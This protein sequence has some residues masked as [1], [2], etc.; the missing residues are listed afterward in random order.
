M[1][2]MFLNLGVAI[3]MWGA[4]GCQSTRMETSGGAAM[5]FSSRHLASSKGA[6]PGALKIDGLFYETTQGRVMVKGLV[7]GGVRPGEATK[8]TVRTSDGRMV[9]IVI[10]P[11]GE[12]YGVQLSAEPSSDITR[13][14]FAVEAGRDEYFTGLMER[15]VDGPQQAS[16][17]PG[18]KSA[19]N[20][21]GTSIRWS[22][23]SV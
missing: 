7:F 4:V 22:V 6:L 12:N 19:M 14:G 15:T 8:G 10:K 18:V 11:D 17:T 21:R 1:N 13:W 16:W 3:L 20:L 2:R 23:V 5:I 9:Q